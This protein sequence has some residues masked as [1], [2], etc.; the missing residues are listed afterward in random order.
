MMSMVVEE[1]HERTCRQ[2]QVREDPKQ[3]GPVLCQQEKEC[4]GKKTGQNPFGPGGHA[5]GMIRVSQ[6]THGDTPCR[7]STLKPVDVLQ[8]PG[9]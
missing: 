1:V 8:L 7:F 3:V 5:S 6:L 2:Q 4:N 9:Q